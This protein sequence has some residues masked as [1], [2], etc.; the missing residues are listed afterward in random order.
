LP[1][2]L[3]IKKESILSPEEIPRRQGWKVTGQGVY[4]WGFQDTVTVGGEI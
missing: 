2:K 1:D 3:G 4:Y